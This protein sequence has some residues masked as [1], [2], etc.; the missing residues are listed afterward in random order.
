MTLTEPVKDVIRDSLGQIQRRYRDARRAAI[1]AGPFGGLMWE[2]MRSLQSP[3]FLAYPRMLAHPKTI[4]AYNDPD[5]QGVWLR[6]FGEAED[7][8]RQLEEWE[9]YHVHRNERLSAICWWSGIGVMLVATIALYCLGLETVGHVSLAVLSTMLTV[10]FFG[11]LFGHT[12]EM[13]AVNNC[14][15]GFETVVREL[16]DRLWTAMDQGQTECRTR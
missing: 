4:K 8:F 3:S 16:P 9:L 11:A 2:A 15:N 5:G 7:R 1:L 13:R 12:I 10:S 6:V 14:R